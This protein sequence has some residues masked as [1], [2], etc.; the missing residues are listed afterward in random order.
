[1]K[2]RTRFW[3]SI[4][5]LGFVSHLNSL[6][7]SFHYDDAHSIVENP[8]VRS[9]ENIPAYFVDPATFSSERTMAMYRPAVQTT[10]AAW[11]TSAQ[12][13]SPRPSPSTSAH[14]KRAPWR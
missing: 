14:S 13:D 8:H 1:M 9:L 6:G 12:V 5:L 10:Y 7:G 3:A 2:E 11:R 4:F